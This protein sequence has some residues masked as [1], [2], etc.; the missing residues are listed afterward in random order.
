MTRSV[1]AVAGNVVL[2]GVQAQLAH[3]FAVVPGLAS[4]MANCM[5][6]DTRSKVRAPPWAQLRLSFRVCCTASAN[7]APSSPSPCSTSTRYRYFYQRRGL[8]CPGAQHREFPSLGTI[9]GERIF[10]HLLVDHRASPRSVDTRASAHPRRPRETSLAGLAGGRPRPRAGAVAPLG[11]LPG[12]DHR[13]HGGDGGCRD[14]G[15]RPPGPAALPRLFRRARRPRRSRCPVGPRRSRRRLPGTPAGALAAP[16][17]TRT[18][19]TRPG[20]PLPGQRDTGPAGAGPPPGELPQPPPLP[21]LGMPTPRAPRRARRPG[22][23]GTPWAGVPSANLCAPCAGVPSG[24]LSHPVPECRREI[25]A[26]RARECRRTDEAH[27]RGRL[28]QPG[29]AAPVTPVT[30]RERTAPVLG[31]R[32]APLPPPCGYVRGIGPSGPVR[33]GCGVPPRT[34]APRAPGRPRGRPRRS[35]PSAPA[36]PGTRATTSGYSIVAGV[37]RPAGTDQGRGRR[38]RPCGP[39]GRAP[40]SLCGPRWMGGVGASTRSAWRGGRCCPPSV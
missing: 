11:H 33:G 22:N 17:P 16:R 30:L 2:R 13:E 7:S 26:H 5:P 15:Q 35:R 37:R 3:H 23:P 28:R 25:S 6:E 24:N 36:V 14:A 18:R 31:A 34:S 27:P 40:T 39:C 8:G 12:D 20:L 19:G 32:A 10:F 4:V 9:G 29:R 38:G 21:L 1:A